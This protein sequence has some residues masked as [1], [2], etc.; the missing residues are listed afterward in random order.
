MNLLVL[1][2]G[3]SGSV[4]LTHNLAT[5]LGVLP[6]FLNIHNQNDINLPSLGPTVYHTHLPKLQ[7]PGFQKI[8]NLRKNSV[9]TILS[10]LLSTHHDFYHRWSGDEKAVEPITVDLE[11]VRYFCLSYIDWHKYYSR[12]LTQDDLV[13]VYETMVERLSS[14]QV[15]ARTYPDKA[16]L[17]VNYQQVVDEISQYHDEFAA[18]TDKFLCHQN[19]NDIYRTI[20]RQQ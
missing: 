12:R 15:Y 18:Y 11:K 19:S 16:T 8:F 1:S 17:M 9:E 10:F 4:L 2:Y 5:G 3:R 20:N 7:A 13:V 14:P 6:K